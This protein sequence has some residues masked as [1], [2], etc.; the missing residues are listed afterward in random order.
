MQH[1]YPPPPFYT[2]HPPPMHTYPHYYPPPILH[3]HDNKFTS[4]DPTTEKRAKSR[5]RAALLKSKVNTLKSSSYKTPQDEKFIRK[6]EEK[7]H[8][9]NT[10]TRQRVAEKRA[11]IET[12]LAKPEAERSS[13]ERD[14]LK[15][16]AAKR[17]RKNENDRLRRVRLKEMGLKSKPSR[18]SPIRGHDDEV[19]DYGYHYH[20][21]ELMEVSELLMQDDDAVGEEGHDR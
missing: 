9:K 2:P 13:Q 14:L 15:I 20:A 3:P 7:R 5:L 4:L 12:I 17:A 16:A 6:F 21:E 10:R 8:K 19:V 11:Q 18:M 1:P